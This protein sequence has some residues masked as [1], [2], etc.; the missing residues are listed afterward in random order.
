MEKK[1]AATK[2]QWLES[3]IIWPREKKVKIQ[4]CWYYFSEQTRPELSAGALFSFA[5]FQRQN[6]LQSPREI[7]F[8]DDKVWAAFL[9][10]YRRG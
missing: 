5:A 2:G 6:Q 10:E 1:D 3:E 9:L 4:K 8:S 7:I